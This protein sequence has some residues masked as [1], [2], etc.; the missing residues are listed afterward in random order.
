MRDGGRYQDQVLLAR[1]TVSSTLSLPQ[2]RYLVALEPAAGPIA[3]A[4]RKGNPVAPTLV[5]T[6]TV[7][8]EQAALCLHWSPTAGHQSGEVEMTAR[9][10][11]ATGH[12]LGS[13]PFT[14]RLETGWEAFWRRLCGLVLAPQTPLLVLA[15]G[16]MTWA[17]QTYRRAEERRL[18]AEGQEALAQVLHIRLLLDRQLA[19]AVRRYDE[20]YQMAQWSPR[21]QNPKALQALDELWAEIAKRDW[22]RDVLDSAVAHLRKEAYQK[23]RADTALVL[24]L[25]PNNEVARDLEKVIELA[26][27]YGEGQTVPEQK[28]RDGDQEAL[29]RVRENYPTL[30]DET[31]LRL[32]AWLQEHSAG[33][34]VPEHRPTYLRWPLLWTAPPPKASRHIEQWLGRVGLTFNPFGPELA[35]ID[36]RLTEYAIDEVYKQ[37]RAPRSLIVIAPYGAGKTAAALRLAFECGYPPSNPDRQGVFP[38][39]YRLRL[40]GEQDRA[41]LLPL[42]RATVRQLLRYLSVRPEKWFDQPLPRRETIQDLIACVYA[43]TPLVLQRSIA[44]LPPAVRQELSPPALRERL[45]WTSL[46]DDLMLDLLPDTRP[47]GFDAY[48]WLVDVPGSLERL[49]PDDLPGLLC[50][51]LS[52]TAHLAPINVRLKL[53]LSPDMANLLG[54]MPGIDRVELK[55]TSGLLKS[56]LETR[57]KRAGGDSLVALCKPGEGE[58]IQTRLIRAAKGS[59]RRLVQLGNAMLDD[60]A[61]RSGDSPLTIKDWQK[62][63]KEQVRQPAVPPRQRYMVLLHQ[64]LDLHFNEEELRTLCFYLDVDYDNLRAIGKVHKARELIKYMERTGRIP[65]LV[66]TLKEIYP[67]VDWDALSSGQ[68]EP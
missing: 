33:G 31:V 34:P 50:R 36:P 19:E 16:L 46:S 63:R 68:A 59:P 9:L 57:I 52:L 42:A 29:N 37:A 58:R 35:E 43:N 17:V 30:L 13:V 55:W 62:A 41:V 24:R 15:A 32:Q 7:P 39:Y 45:P 54:H 53:F 47:I 10:L 20:C 66:A 2:T 48:E 22:Q 3:Y 4:D 60:A 40:T 56:M 51:L 11:D 8:A 21:W 1:L 18:E 14:V 67:R 26:Q 6:P 28:G 61:R 12:E 64:A 49:L 27:R 23:A 5:L 44:R 25:D 65:D 38:V